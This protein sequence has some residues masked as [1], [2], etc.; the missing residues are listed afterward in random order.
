MSTSLSADLYHSIFAFASLSALRAASLTS[1]HLLSAARPFLFRRIVLKDGD[2]K[3]TERLE[4]FLS[5]EEGR[6]AEYVRD[7]YFDASILPLGREQEGWASARILLEKV[8]PNLKV[9]TVEGG[10]LDYTKYQSYLSSPLLAQF[11]VSVVQ[12][13]KSLTTLRL[14]SRFDLSLRQ[15][16]T[17][18]HNLEQLVLRHTSFTSQDNSSSPVVIL[19]ALRTLFLPGFYSG[20]QCLEM[21]LQPVLH[22]STLRGISCLHILLDDN[23]QSFQMDLEFLVPYFPQLEELYLPETVSETASERSTKLIP[24]DQFSRLSHVVFQLNEIWVFE[25]IAPFFGW[26]SDHF[27]NPFALKQLSFH[28]HLKGVRLK[29]VKGVEHLD[30]SGV[31]SPKIEFVLH[32]PPGTE[33]QELE[34]INWVEGL[35]ESLPQ[36]RRAARKLEIIRIF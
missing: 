2:P 11:M 10:S 20:E 13:A 21:V 12:A 14:H 30:C 33:N 26:V 29:T 34:Y 7:I 19:P 35:F 22:A 36:L 15:I 17:Q 3:L 1:S 28:I 23:G 32:R 27:E 4:F 6:F 16:L 25:W 8:A 24:L 5:Y 18:T 9:W 31:V